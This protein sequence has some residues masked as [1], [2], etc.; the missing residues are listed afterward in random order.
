MLRFSLGVTRLDRIRNEYIRGTAH[1]GRLGDKVREARLRWFGHV[2]R[3]EVIS[4]QKPWMTAEVCALLKSRD[5]AF[6]AGDKEALRTARTK[7]S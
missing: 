5:S 4:N 3:R 1:V 2:Q 6:R 7:L